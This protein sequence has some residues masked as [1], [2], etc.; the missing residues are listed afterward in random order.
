MHLW[1]VLLAINV[2][3]CYNTGM[4]LIDTNLNLYKSF[5]VVFETRNL[6]RAANILYI[7]RSAIGQNIKALNK[8][9][10]TTLFTSGRKGVEPT[11]DAFTLY[12][13]IK[14]ALESIINAENCLEKFDHDST[15][16]I[17]MAMPALFANL[18]ISDYLK[19]FCA[20]Y[21][22]VRLEFF[23]RESMDL[24]EQRKIDFIIDDEYHFRDTDFRTI[25][26]TVFNGIF[27]ATKKFLAKN[28]LTR[29]LSIEKLLK[30]KIIVTR[31][32]WAEFYRQIDVDIEPFV[33][34]T[35]SSDAVYSM[36]AN[37]I[38]VGYF[39]KELLEKAQS[40]NLVTL[41]VP[42]VTFPALKI[43]CGYNKSLTQPA[44]AFVDG[45][46][47]FCRK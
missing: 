22:K 21:P 6:S 3:L 44:R 35:P 46:L 30:L 5:M 28:K 45:L 17:K 25:K 38:G 2:I 18:Y 42:G 10:K 41:N 12:P 7:S 43:V 40:S 34:K 33:I 9:L 26:L 31:T 1:E 27:I 16:V 32:A 39:H 23:N 20:K 8:Q 11:S 36:V 15:A 47:A 19:A 4:K 14:N 37:S 29:N 13:V 24:L